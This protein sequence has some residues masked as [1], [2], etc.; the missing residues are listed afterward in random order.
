[1]ENRHIKAY[2]G[3]LVNVPN[4]VPEPFLFYDIANL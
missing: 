1:L 4:I 3:M 2:S